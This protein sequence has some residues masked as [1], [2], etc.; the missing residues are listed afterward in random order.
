M[1]PKEREQE[2]NFMPHESKEVICLMEQ[3]TEN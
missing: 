3:N 1:K 2:K